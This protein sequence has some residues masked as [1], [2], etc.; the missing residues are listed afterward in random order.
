MSLNMQ[1]QEKGQDKRGEAALPKPT[2]H[3]SA[4]S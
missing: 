1:E 3:L 4:S 2:H